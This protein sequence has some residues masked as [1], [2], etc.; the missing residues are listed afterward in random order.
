MIPLAAALVALSAFSNA[1]NLS[2]PTAAPGENCAEAL[3]LA[4]AKTN[5]A[6]HFGNAAESRGECAY[7]VRTSLQ[8]SGVG[9][10]TGGIGN[11]IDYVKNLPNYGFVVT[12]MT[13][14]RTAVPGSVIVLAGPDSPRYLATGK[15]GTPP[16]NWLGHVTIKGD[17]GYYYTDAR[18]VEPAIGWE[19]G[20]DVEDIRTVAGIFVPGAALVSQYAGKCPK[21][22]Q[23]GTALSPAD[24][25]AI[26]HPFKVPASAGGQTACAN[27]GDLEDAAK[28]FQGLDYRND[29]DR[30]AGYRLTSPLIQQFQK[31][32]S[33][34][35]ASPDRI[36][37]FRAL[38][39]TLRE[40]APYDGEG[41][42]TQMLAQAIGA[43]PALRSEYDDYVGSLGDADCKTQRLTAAVDLAVCM[44]NLGMVGQDFVGETPAG[45]A[46]SCRGSF[47]FLTCLQA[48]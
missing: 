18:T 40:A 37:V 17:D 30:R 14:P 7:G 11:A 12:S 5:V 1:A 34:D 23:E 41:R 2:G 21:S 19:N 43:D 48:R 47:D 33:L 10:L 8:L 36:A 16:G 28:G 20:V 22:S 6:K 25:P 3:V 24:L 39:A 32:S 31:F 4:A 46:D 9:G 42:L 38:L 13:D 45:A 27:C 15:F 29:A 35:P 26:F 44:K